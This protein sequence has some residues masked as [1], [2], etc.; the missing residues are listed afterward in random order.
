MPAGDFVAAFCLMLA[1]GAFGAAQ[2]QGRIEIEVPPARHVNFLIEGETHPGGPSPAPRSRLALRLPA[3]RDGTLIKP[4]DLNSLVETLREALPPEYRRRLVAYFGFSRRGET[5]LR[6]GDLRLVDIAS[7]LFD[8]FDLGNRSTL[9]GRQISCVSSG[10]RDLTP[11]FALVVHREMML[12]ESY[13][14]RDDLP[15][16]TTVRAALTLA[17]RLAF[18]CREGR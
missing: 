10:E 5:T 15:R 9:L 18:V 14:R 12:D 11:V 2:A 1:S 8:L 13:T 7:L 3:A 17:N 16:D 4:A 6:P